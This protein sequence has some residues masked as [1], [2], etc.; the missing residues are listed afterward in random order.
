MEIYEMTLILCPRVGPL[1]H[2]M[3]IKLVLP[4]LESQ[5]LK[6]MRKRS[7]NPDVSSA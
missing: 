5:R 4:I 2:R 1:V 6:M 3:Y 7:L